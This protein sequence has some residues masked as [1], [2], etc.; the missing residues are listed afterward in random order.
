MAEPITDATLPVAQHV[1]SL[2]ARA[3]T[4]RGGA[5]GAAVAWLKRLTADYAKPETKAQI[6]ELFAQGTPPRPVGPSRG[7]VIG[8]ADWTGLDVKGR[9]VFSFVKALTGLVG[10]ERF[11]LGKKYNAQGPS[12]NEWTN[13]FGRFARFVFPGVLTKK[14]KVWE[15]LDM[16]TY[17]EEAVSS[18]GTQALILD[19]STIESNPKLGRN[20]R[21]EVVQLVPGVHLAR[22]MWHTGK[23]YVRIA[24]W[25]ETTETPAQDAS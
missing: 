10:S 6:D 4:D 20:I 5:Q 15:G 3:E 2:R 9:V 16:I 18:P 14:G 25:Y 22:K 13:L 8:W 17:V 19:F 12:S 24:D 21:D 23:G 7:H 1:E 11:W